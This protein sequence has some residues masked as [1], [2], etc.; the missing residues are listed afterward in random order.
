VFLSEVY[1]QRYK[2]FILIVALVDLKS[3]N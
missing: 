1:L 2:L 3:L